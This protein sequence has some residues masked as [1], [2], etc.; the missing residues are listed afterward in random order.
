MLTVVLVKSTASL[1]S[2]GKSEELEPK[3]MSSPEM[4]I[5]KSNTP[6]SISMV[7]PK[8]VSDEYLLETLMNSLC[9]LSN[10]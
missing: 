1:K 5:P 8:S 4:L 9:V 10:S 6:A 7:T 3:P 2:S